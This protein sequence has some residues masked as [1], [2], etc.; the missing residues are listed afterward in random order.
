M[1][2]PIGTNSTNKT[3]KIRSV[4]FKNFASY[5]NR[6][7]RIDF[8]ENKGELY[9]VLGN[10]GAGK[11]SL[12]KVITYLC[13]GRVEGSNLRDL[14]NR[15]NS[16]LWGRIIMESK[17]NLVQ[18]ERGISPGIFSVKINETE[19]DVAGK[20]NLQDFLETEIFEI[21]YH[22]FKNVIILSVND[23]KSFITMSNADKKAIVDRIFGF[24][25]INEMRE[26]IKLQRKSVIEEIR[27][28]EDEIRTLG[29]SIASVNARIIQFEA[30]KKKKDRTR[31]NDLKA[32]LVE[33][34]A[35]KERLKGAGSALK[36]RVEEFDKTYRQASTKRTQL[37]AELK[38][39]KSALTLYHNQKCP[40]CSSPLNTDF[41]H[42]I[43]A[44]HE[45]TQ[46]GLTSEIDAAAATVK[47]IEL[48]LAKA[49][50]QARQVSVKAGQLET[51]MQ[52]I[53][54]ELI[55][56][57]SE[58]SD[59]GQH[60]RQLIE[61]FGQKKSTKAEDRIKADGE[62]YYLTALESILGEDG[63]KHLAVKSILPAFNNNI[64][65]MAREMGIPFGIV[66]DEKFNCMLYHLGEEISPRTLS[67][68]EKKK[69]DF[70]IVM[71]LIKMIKNRFP[72]LNILFLDEIFSS[73]DL[74][75]VYHIIEILHQIIGEIGINTFV[76]NHTVLPSEYFDKKLEIT[77]D[78]GFSEFIIEE[79]A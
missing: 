72:G 55:K 60:L 11:S 18:I 21:P 75:G 50:E 19:Y 32:K 52:G 69:I 28:L 43:K 39:V 46:E 26:A 63:I 3:M 33:M 44:E 2:L 56:L 54:D 30:S 40:T 12:A 71:A 6:V 31:I 5:G 79:I 58:K 27:S 73:V 14:P 76:I 59:D 25:V 34:S 48:D 7:Q 49:R 15:V 13:Y 29:D 23:F 17:G 62:N 22:V 77:K 64:M 41:H 66:F 74:S 68:G 10:N 36:V 35:A 78:S 24:S 51:Q 70:V 45:V 16:S 38:S 37:G 47:H 65:L 1:P 61:E 42:N 4:E 57:A 67:T 8:E 9:L 20:S 53:K